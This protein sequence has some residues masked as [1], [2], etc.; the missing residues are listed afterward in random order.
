MAERADTPLVI[1]G[2]LFRRKLRHQRFD[3]LVRAE[4]WR[5][6]VLAQENVDGPAVTDSFLLG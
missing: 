5:G 2:T 1:A 3:G 6:N 4:V